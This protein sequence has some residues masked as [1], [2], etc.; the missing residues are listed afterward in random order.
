MDSKNS[1]PL[2]CW[3]VQPLDPTIFVHPFAE[4][5]LEANV[6]ANGEAN[7]EPIARNSKTMIKFYYKIMF[8]VNFNMLFEESW[9]QASA[10]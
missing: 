8:Y 6:E 7:P 9:A 10:G 1:L 2:K 3:F 4:A 5:T